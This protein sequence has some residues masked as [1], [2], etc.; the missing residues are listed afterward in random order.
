M[1]IVAIGPIISPQG[2]CYPAVPPEVPS[3][4]RAAPLKA[5]VE[6]SDI[7]LSTWR[8]M[9]SVP[10]RALVSTE[11]IQL[12][13]WVINAAACGATVLAFSSAWSNDAASLRCG[14][15]IVKL[16]GVAVHTAAAAHAVI[17]CWPRG[18]P[19]AA[20]VVRRG[21]ILTLWLFA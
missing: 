16:G 10:A 4:V 7:R 5:L 8:V 3:A 1:D 6:T 17:G 2:N 12:T 18:Q 9:P 19:L 14:D 13:T 20:H 21:E 11:D 15:C